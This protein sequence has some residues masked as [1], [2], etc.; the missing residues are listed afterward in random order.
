MSRSIW[1]CLV[2]Q[3]MLIPGVEDWKEIAADFHWLWAFPNC[4]VA[5]YGKHVIIQALNNTGSQ[6]YNYKGSFSIVLLA[7]DDSR[8]CFRVVDVGDFGR[9]SDEE[10]LAASAFG[11]ALHHGTLN[12]KPNEA[13]SWTHRTMSIPFVTSQRDSGVCLF[14]PRHSVEA[15]PQNHWCFSLG[16]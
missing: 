13:L 4:C 14:Y 12:L 3:L 6:F 7:V 10:T 5:I 2:P 11:K 16:G 15:L 1:D 8:W 9:S